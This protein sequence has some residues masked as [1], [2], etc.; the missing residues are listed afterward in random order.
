MREPARKRR[1]SACSAIVLNPPLAR[2]RW[3]SNHPSIWR[4][5]SMH[6]NPARG[7]RRRCNPT[8]QGCRRGTSRHFGLFFVAAGQAGAVCQR[9]R[10]KDDRAGRNDR[11]TA[12]LRELPFRRLSR[13]KGHPQTCRSAPPLSGTEDDRVQ[14]WRAATSGHSC[15]CRKTRR[16]GNRSA[17][18]LLR[19]ARALT[20]R[21]GPHRRQ[22]QRRT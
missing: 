21:T 17:Q 5:R 11:K 4:L 10:S 14:T 8:L 15:G 2:R 19:Q 13:R 1:N 7:S 6:S 16:P 3:S 22:A 12:E 9:S 18:R 20:L